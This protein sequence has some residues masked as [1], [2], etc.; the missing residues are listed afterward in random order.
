MS[1]KD[2]TSPRRR[3][4]DV[5]KKKVAMN[6]QLRRGEQEVIMRSPSG[7]VGREHFGE[8]LHGVLVPAT[9]SAL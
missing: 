6:Q 4:S 9:L 7:G 2:V 8:V 1:T 5:Q 3:G